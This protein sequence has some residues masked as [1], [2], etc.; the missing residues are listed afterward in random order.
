MV[1]AKD[2]GFVEDPK[3]KSVQLARRRQ[4]MTE[5]LFHDDPRASS[6]VRFRQVPHDG[7]EQNRRDC[8]VVRWSSRVLE[9]LAQRNEGCR[10]LVIAVNVSQQGDQFFES[11]RIDSAMF[12]QAVFRASAKLINIP[13]SFGYANDGHVQ[14]ASLHHRLQRGENLSVGEIASGTEENKRV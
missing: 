4:I 10:V 13:S 7:F 11:F 6:A 14:V 9:R 8:Q 1:D 5:G 3:Q 2:V 12:L